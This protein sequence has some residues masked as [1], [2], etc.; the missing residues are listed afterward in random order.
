MG[1]CETWQ[2]I[3][4]WINAVRQ[5]QKVNRTEKK[6]R[7]YQTKKRKNKMYQ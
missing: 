5:D 4:I 2:D 3:N 6:K 7:G 1:V